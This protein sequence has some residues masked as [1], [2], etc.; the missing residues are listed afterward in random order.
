MIVMTKSSVLALGRCKMCGWSTKYSAE[1]THSF[2]LHFLNRCQVDGKDRH[3]GCVVEVETT[4]RIYPMTDL[5]YMLPNDA[6]LE[7]S[8]S[9]AV[10][11]KLVEKARQ[12][13]C[14]GLTLSEAVEFALLSV[15]HMPCS[16]NK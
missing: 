14:D 1:Q 12:A 6:W 13:V 15:E 8:E 9:L 7:G 4:G 5:G 2:Q 3:D 11:K 10:A 16:N